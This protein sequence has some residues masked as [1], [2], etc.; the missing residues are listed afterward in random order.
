MRTRLHI[1]PYFDITCQNCAKSWSTDF[2]GNAKQMG[3]FGNGGMGMATDRKWLERAAHNS[4]WRCRG[5]KTLCPE[6][7]ASLEGS[8]NE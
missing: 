5:G 8:R 1:D 6:C 2:D 4:G 3:R 7:V